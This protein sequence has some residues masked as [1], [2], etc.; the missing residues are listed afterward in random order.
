MLSIWRSARANWRPGSLYDSTDYSMESPGPNRLWSG[1]SILSVVSSRV[2]VERWNNLPYN[3]SHHILYSA[4]SPS[5]LMCV[6]L[7]W[8]TPPGCCIWPQVVE[9]NLRNRYHN[10]VYFVSQVWDNKWTFWFYFKQYPGWALYTWHWEHAFEFAQ[11]LPLWQ[12]FLVLLATPRC[13]S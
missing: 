4:A 5:G 11:L 1:L 7:Q 12:G 10:S 6:S 8:L 9:D 3:A 13:S 2:E